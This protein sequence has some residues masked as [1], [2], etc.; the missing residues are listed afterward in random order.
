[1]FPLS[2]FLSH[3]IQVGTL[4]VTDAEDGI[5]VFTGSAP[6]PSVHM[7]LSDAHLYRLLFFNPE[8]ADG[9]AYMNGTLTFPG[10]SL[11]EFLNLLSLNRN[12]PGGTPGTFHRIIATI[13]RQF[14]R[15][16]QSNPIGKTQQHIAHHYDIGNELYRLF[17]DDV[18]FYSCAYFENDE[19]TLEATGQM[20]ADCREAGFTP[21]PEAPRY[22]LRVGWLRDLSRADGGCSRPRRWP[23]PP[24][25]SLSSS[26]AVQ[27]RASTN[28]C[29]GP[30]PRSRDLTSR[31]V[32][33]LA[34]ISP[35]CR[36]LCL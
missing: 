36:S 18:L 30:T 24:T 4:T 19:D 23:G 33:W 13:S 6:G 22:R 32:H 12:R 25:S 15:F 21:R 8:L 9:E 29:L 20:Q 26:T 16:Q 10:S 31:C 28:S 35:G 1:M 7:K 17:L 14:K 3:L 5:H 11:R 27:H 2:K 34:Y